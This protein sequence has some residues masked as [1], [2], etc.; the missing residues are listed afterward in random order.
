MSARV[1]SILWLCLLAIA[2][3]SSA[4]PEQPSQHRSVLDTSLQ[5]IV[6]TT[7]DW[8]AVDGRLQMYQRSSADGPWQ[9]AGGPIAIVIGKGGMA[10]GIGVDPL[11]AARGP[12]DPVKR[13]GDHKS[14][15]GIFRLGDAFGYAPREPDGWKLRY[16]PITPST[17]CVDDP[18]S[19]FYNQILDSSAVAVDWKSAEHMRDAGEAYRWGL[20]VDQNPR[21]AHPRGGSC[22]FMHIWGGAGMGTEGC[23]AMP[24]SQIEAVLAWL[25]PHANPLLVQMPLR[26]YQQTARYLHLPA[27]PTALAVDR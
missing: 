5:L 17:Q 6:V 13:E 15:A 20:V 24:E 12:A 1:K 27:P 25:R 23:T 21:P 8:N 26:E 18:Q 22:V 14:P 3:A 16:L 7:P 9:A 10:W 2:A 19:Q 4:F 11:D